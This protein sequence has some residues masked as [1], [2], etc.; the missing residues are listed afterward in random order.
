MSEIKP[1][2]LF[3]DSQMLFWKYDERFFLESVKEY[4]TDVSP[5]AA[6][7]GASNGDRIEF[8]EFFREAMNNIGINECRLISAF[9]EQEDQ[10]FLKKADII[11]LSGGDV[12][13]GW[14]T[15]QAVGLD[16]AI[17][18]RYGEGALLMG[19]SAGAIHLGQCALP[20]DE[21]V[22]GNAFNTLRIL[23]FVVGVHEQ[24]TDW[25]DLKQLVSIEGSFHR[26]VGIPTGGGLI[27]HTDFSVEPLRFPLQE[28]IYE[29]RENKLSEN[30][31]YPVLRKY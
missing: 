1:I 26:G 9:F 5:K 22:E 3:A 30:L 27:Y 15:F 2:Y 7:I 18:K 14:K 17:Q 21:P 29:Y 11:F 6:Y 16:T 19:V 8:Y 20:E 10:D 12:A 31:L 4:I 28:F 25:R 24:K 13:L 23:P